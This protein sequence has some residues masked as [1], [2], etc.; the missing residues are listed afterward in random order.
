MFVLGLLLRASYAISKYISI[1][2]NCCTERLLDL[3]A[4]REYT[5]F[6]VTLLLLL[7]GVLT[8]TAVHPTIP[9]IV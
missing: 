9:S 4:A 5:F 8:P 2:V 7:Q 1:N 6:I 3:H